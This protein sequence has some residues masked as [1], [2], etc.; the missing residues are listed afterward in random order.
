[1]KTMSY[2]TRTEYITVQKHRYKRAG[3]P[4]KTRL[5]DEVCEVCGYERKHAIKL[6]NGSLTPS[7]G[8][9]GRKSEY[10]EP[11]FV[12]ALK[13]LWLRSGQLCGKRL[14]PAIPHWIEHYEKHYSTLSDSCHEKLLRISPASIDR[15]LK[16]FKAQY[17]RRCNTGTKPGTLLKNQIPIRTSTED[18]DRP[19]YLEADT[20]AHCGGSMNGN[21]IWSITYTDIVSTW[22]VTRA[23]WNKGAAGVLEQTRD[24]EKKLPF[25][26][27]GFDCDNGSEF[28]NHHLTRYFLRRKQPVGFTRSRPYH[29]NDNAHVEQKNWTHV[30]ELLGY[31]R[32]DNPAMLKEINALYRD[33]EQLNNFFKPSLKLKSKVRVK[34][35]YKKKYDE[36]ATPF[37][38]L[39]ASGILSKKQEAALQHEYESLDPFGL[40]NR[41]QRRLRKIEKMKK[42]G[43][44]AAVGEPG[45]PDCPRSLTTPELAGTH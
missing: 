42:T 45:F 31:D 44:L 4:Y 7:C 10:A 23:V 2:E 24:V 37:D 43:E 40:G 20:V 35:R 26:I 6:L 25:A 32:L 39:K 33:W 17:R 12:K 8:K 5:L 41:I 11:E 15:V 1:M 16:P 22:T 21:F 9:R 28:L 13:T 34:S 36:P 18:I 3:K 27:I 30:R 19:G 38:R 29:K 14:R